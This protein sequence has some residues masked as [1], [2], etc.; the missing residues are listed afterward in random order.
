MQPRLPNIT[1]TEVLL[2]CDA[3]VQ[4]VGEFRLTLKIEINLAA[5]KD[6]LGK[7]SPASRTKSGRREEIAAERF[8]SRARAVAQERLENFSSLIEKQRVQLGRL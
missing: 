2:D 6:R 3:P 4:S 5:G 1:T 7:K 8:V